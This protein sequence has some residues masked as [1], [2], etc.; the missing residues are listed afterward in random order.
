MNDNLVWLKLI[1]FVALGL[2]YLAVWGAERFVPLTATDAMAAYFS[3]AAGAT[4]I[5]FLPSPRNGVF[6]PILLSGPPIHA[7][8]C[9]FLGTWAA[10]SQAPPS[11]FAML[12]VSAIGII[13]F[14]AIVAAVGK[15]MVDSEKARQESKRFLDQHSQ[16]GPD[17]R[18]EAGHDY[19][20]DQGPSCPG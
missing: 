7:G 11:S 13:G 15:L 20:G 12:I 1:L 2:I 4:L 17:S 16:G 19:E 8:I 18:A 3:M 6:G 10:I 14:I 5:H 9:G